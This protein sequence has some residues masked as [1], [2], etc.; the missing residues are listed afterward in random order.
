M[1]VNG[2]FGQLTVIDIDNNRDDDWNIPP[3]MKHG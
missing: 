2:D 1:V 3:V